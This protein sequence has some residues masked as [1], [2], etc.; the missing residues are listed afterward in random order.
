MFTN[1]FFKL[2]SAGLLL[3]VAAFLVKG[4]I[5]RASNEPSVDPAFHT[6]PM[7]DYVPVDNSF[8]TPPMSDYVPVD[9][10][11]HTP[12]MSDYVPPVDH[13]FH[14]PPMSDYKP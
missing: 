11:F 8:H 4:T 5:A 10:S 2:L 3:V 1:R 6:P 14:T 9:R 13:S 12:P 7:S